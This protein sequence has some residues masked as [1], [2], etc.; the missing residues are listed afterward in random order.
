MSNE[1]R[2]TL[3]DRLTRH[4]KGILQ[5]MEETQQP[6][7][8]VRRQER[9][10]RGKAKA[11]QAWSENRAR[12]REESIVQELAAVEAVEVAPAFPGFDFPTLTEKLK[13]RIVTTATTAEPAEAS[14][15]QEMAESARQE[16]RASAKVAIS[17]LNKLESRLTRIAGSSTQ[18][19]IRGGHRSPTFDMLDQNGDGVI[20]RAEWNVATKG[21]GS[22]LGQQQGKRKTTVASA[23]GAKHAE[24][25]TLGAAKAPAMLKELDA[26]FDRIR[27]RIDAMKGGPS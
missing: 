5:T 25:Q 2:V 11:E 4:R 8:E 12:R 3:A 15:L 26:E 18:P 10:Q 20:S 14:S 23:R 16:H 17:E 22:P 1:V 7:A 27:Q 6:V 21:A 24:L 13:Q 9:Q 19:P